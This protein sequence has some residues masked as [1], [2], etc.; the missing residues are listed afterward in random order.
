MVIL[1]Q[2]R[3]EEKGQGCS[4]LLSSSLSFYAETEAFAEVPPA[5]I[6]TSLISLLAKMGPLHEVVSCGVSPDPQ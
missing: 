2:P 6:D 4:R 5:S 1:S 3:K